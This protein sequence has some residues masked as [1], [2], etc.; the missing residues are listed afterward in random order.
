MGE[1]MDILKNRG[2]YTICI[3]LITMLLSTSTVFGL[4]HKATVIVPKTTIMQE[5]NF[6]SKQLDKLKMGDKITV[7]EILDDW[8]RIEIPNCQNEGWIPSQDVVINGELPKKTSIRKGCVTASVLNVRLGPSTSNARI[9]Q[10]RCGETV[11]I[12]NVSGTPEK[13]YEVIL[14]NNVKGWVHSDYIKI[15]YNFPKGSVNIDSIML[16]QQP[17]SEAACITKLKKDETVYI[18]DYVEGWYNVISSIDTEGWV[19]NKN[20][21]VLSAETINVNR[22]GSNRE[23]LIYRYYYIKVFGKKY[24]YGEMVQIV[25]IVPVLHHIY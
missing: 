21:T 20:I 24:A 3:G 19:E 8:Y 2:K 17:N 6:N 1:M 4:D 9:A 13:W 25:L 16:K 23:I 11:T 12:I 7:K 18:K 5:R 22:S 15:T 10:I 14:S